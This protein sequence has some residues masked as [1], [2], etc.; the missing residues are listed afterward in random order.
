[1]AFKPGTDDL[2][3]SP[4][5]RVIEEL[6]ARRAEV[7][8]F[9]PAVGPSSPAL[10]GLPGLGS[11]R[12]AGSLADTVLG[13]D[14]AILVTAWPEFAR[15]DPGWSELATTMRRPLLLDGRNLL[16]ADPP[17]GFE[18]LRIGRRQVPKSSGE[19]KPPSSRV[20][21]PSTRV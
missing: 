2:R 21:A 15:P 8:A 14:A 18:Y 17:A 11:V 6:T 12:I 13:A 20:G 3:D 16:A 9:D 4:A 1:M 10:A 7:S 19:A 5:L